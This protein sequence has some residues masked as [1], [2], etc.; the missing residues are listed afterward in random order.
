VEWVQI[1][2]RQRLLTF[3]VNDFQKCRIRW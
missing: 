3:A 1:T 2:R